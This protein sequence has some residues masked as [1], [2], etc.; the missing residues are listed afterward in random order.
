MEEVTIYDIAKMAGV[1][2]STVSRV[3]NN[4]PH[5]KKATR[6]KILKL[7]EEYH[8]VPNETARGLVSQ[9]S[10]M[11]GI[12]ISDIRMT[13]HTDGVYF[14]ERELSKQG[15]SCLIY[16]TGV[17]EDEQA[18]SIQLVSQ[19][20]V[21]AAILMGSIYQNDAVK[22]A[23]RTYLPTTPIIICNGHLEAPNIYS[24]IADEENGV[25]N[26]VRLLSDK[27]RQHPAF[28]VD[29][30]TPSNR[31][32]QKGFEAGVSQYFENAEPIIIESG[33]LIQDVYG[34]TVKLMREHPETDGIIYAE[35]LMALTG[36]R[37]LSELQISIPKDVAVIGINNSK[38]TE[39]GNPPLTSLDN[40]MYDLSLTAARNLVALLQG[41]RVNKKMI[42]CSEIVER[43]T[44]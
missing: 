15:Y 11:I 23:I 17:R 40:M 8:Y 4:Y 34:A 31:L 6:A 7:L 24:V 1:S 30:N 41:E 18:R 10:K 19:R 13:Q 9:S 37:A 28:I 32:K 44:T 29:H 42:I 2:A 3:V 25:Y 22:D 39:M 35:D 43:K 5:V 16:N 36:V 33:T 12:L 14:I 27:G 20:K 38:Y 26:C 21:D